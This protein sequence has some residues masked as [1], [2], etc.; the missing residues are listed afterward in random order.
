MSLSMPGWSCAKAPVRSRN[1]RN[2]LVDTIRNVTNLTPTLDFHYKFS[3]QS[4]IWLHYRGDTRQPDITQLLDITDALRFKCSCA[5]V[6]K[7]FLRSA[8]KAAKPS[9]MRLRRVQ[10]FF[11]RSATKAAK[12]S[13]MRLRRV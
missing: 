8:T 4:N 2:I 6:Q 3:D 1:Y 5:A 11:L 13:A 7:F 9:A 10:K 12:P